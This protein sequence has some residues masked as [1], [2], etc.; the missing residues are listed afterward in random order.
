MAPGDVESTSDEGAVPRSEAGE[1]DRKWIEYRTLAVLAAVPADIW[2]G[3]SLPVPIEQIVDEHFGLFI[4]EE[5]DLETAPGCPKL[6]PDQVL[7]AL[8]IADEREIWVSAGEAQRWPQRRRFSIAHELGHWH[9]HRE[10]Q[11]S[12]FCRRAALDEREERPSKAERRRRR[13]ERP[14]LPL[15]EEEANAFASAL[16][17]PRHLLRHHYAE[18][19]KDFHRLCSIFGSSMAAM[20]RRLHVAI[21]RQD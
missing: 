17:M 13:K 3:E 12:L 5:A 18:T 6:E 14:R 4:R 11:Q 2:D 20:G 16:L 10:G 7:S 1:L 9:L 21:P 19:N 15:A 8:L